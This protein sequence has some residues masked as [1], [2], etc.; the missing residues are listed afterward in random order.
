MVFTKDTNFFDISLISVSFKS[1]S[2]IGAIHHTRS[3]IP[4]NKIKCTPERSFQCII[5]EIIIGT[6][7]VH[8]LYLLFM[9]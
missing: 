8:P 7:L 2:L 3:D 5:A 1:V 6:I 4:G 9:I